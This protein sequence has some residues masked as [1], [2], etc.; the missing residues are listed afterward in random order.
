MSPCWSRHPAYKYV[1][2]ICDL[3]S[4]QRQTDCKVIGQRWGWG[5]TVYLGECSGGKEVWKDKKPK[6]GV[7]FFHYWKLDVFYLAPLFECC[8]KID[9][10]HLDQTWEAIVFF[11]PFEYFPAHFSWSVEKKNSFF[12]GQGKADET[13]SNGQGFNIVPPQDFKKLK[14]FKDV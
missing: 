3:T 11:S 5:S 9:Q 8:T 4:V 2:G 6:S 14:V 12:T 13:K 7:H 1:P 10:V